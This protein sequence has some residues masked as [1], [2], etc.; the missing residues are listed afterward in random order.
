MVLTK[1]RNVKLGVFFSEAI[2]IW[3]TAKRGNARKDRVGLFMSAPVYMSTNLMETYLLATISRKTVV[4]HRLV[5][6]LAHTLLVRGGGSH[7]K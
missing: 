1:K 4:P 6:S 5:R 3:K 2:L 7:E